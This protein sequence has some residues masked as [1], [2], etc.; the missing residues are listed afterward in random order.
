MT[1]LLAVSGLTVRIGGLTAVSELGF[2]VAAGE[3]ISLIGPNGAGKTT[4]F[5]AIT[6]YIRPRAGSVRFAGA[7]MLGLAPER[8]AERGLVRSFQRTSI[9][10][11]CTVLENTLMALHL[12]GRAGLL[13]AF[14]RLPAV[15]R[16]EA[17]LRAEAMAMLHTV[18]LAGRAAVAAGALAY[19]EQRR[20]GIALAAAAAPRL[21]LLDEPA[22]GL[23]PSETVECMT[24]I[25]SLR[26]RGTSILLVEHDM[27]MV[28]GISDRI[29]VLNQG[30]LIAAGSPAEVRRDPEVIRAYLG[31]MAS[32]AAA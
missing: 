17:R 20:L 28:M 4:A 23:N 7:E 21:L 27:A 9:F 24:L 2:A 30:Q 26:D 31:S 3:I 19:G 18:G 12:R 25:R 22:A 29:I 14:L 5:N 13:G 8:I 6:G 32:D 16:E 10:D 11:R 1:A 15:R